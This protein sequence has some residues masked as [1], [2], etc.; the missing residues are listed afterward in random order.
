MT[1]HLAPQ[2]SQFR[3]CREID[4]VGGEGRGQRSTGT[5]RVACPKRSDCGERREKRA[6]KRVETGER[7]ASI[8]PAFF[9]V[10]FSA[11]LPYSSSLSPQSERLEQAQG[12]KT[13]VTGRSLREAEEMGKTFATVPNILQ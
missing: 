13:A 11:P 10:L 3:H 4:W 2:L 7:G 9:R 5:G 8:F 6:G 12:E 1:F